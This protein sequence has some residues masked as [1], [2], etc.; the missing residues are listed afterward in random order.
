MSIKAKLEKVTE[1]LSTVYPEEIRRKIEQG[2]QE[3]LATQSEKGAKNMGDQAPLFTLPNTEGKQISLSEFIGK[4][5]TI[6]VFY[7][8]EWCRYCYTYLTALEEKFEDFKEAGANLIAITPQVRKYALSQKEKQNLSFE[9]LT[10]G[11]NKIAEAFGLKTPVP[12]SHLEALAAAGMPLDK[13]NGEAGKDSTPMAATYI[14]DE[15]G[16]IVWSFINRD[17]RLRGEPREILD[18]LKN[19]IKIRRKHNDA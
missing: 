14:L 13:I 19:N 12:V 10:D 6:L 18:F 17:Y 5:K 1:E 8:G 15:E 7:R 11:E 16:K 9:I 2:N 4:G 3:I